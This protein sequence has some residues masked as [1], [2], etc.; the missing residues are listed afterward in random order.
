MVV[1]SIAKLLDPQRVSVSDRAAGPERLT[2][3]QE[4]G[5]AGRGVDYEYPLGVS[6]RCEEAARDGARHCPPE[7]AVAR[8]EV[9]AA[10][11]PWQA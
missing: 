6:R 3:G 2:R 1:T 10:V 8:S 7:L 9:V 11:P 5:F 4:G